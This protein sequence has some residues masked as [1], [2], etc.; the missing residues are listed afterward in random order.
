MLQTAEEL[1]RAREAKLRAQEE[2]WEKLPLFHPG[3]TYTA[4]AAENGFRV[5]DGYSVSYNMD[6]AVMVS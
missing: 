6:G 2:E 1:L 3:K 5:I 4:D